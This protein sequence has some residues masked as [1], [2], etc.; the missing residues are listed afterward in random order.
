[1]FKI[2]YLNP[3][4]YAP[5]LAMVALPLL[6]GPGCGS[7]SAP[8]ETENPAN[9]TQSSQEASV[10]VSFFRRADNM[11]GSGTHYRVALEITAGSAAL[12]P[13]PSLFGGLLEDGSSIAAV[14]S[15][16]PFN[17]VV[18]C[19]A[20]DVLPPDATTEC[21]ISLN[22]SDDRDALAVVFSGSSQPLEAPLP[23]EES[24][25]QLGCETQCSSCDGMADNEDISCDDL[26]NA[27]GA[28][29]AAVDWWGGACPGDQ[30]IA[31]CDPSFD[32]CVSRCQASS[33]AACIDDGVFQVDTW[34]KE[35]DCV[36][37]CTMRSNKGCVVQPNA[38]SCDAG[39][40]NG[41]YI[42]LYEWANCHNPGGI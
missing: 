27:C 31:L 24:N 17:G 3:L 37:A 42:A 4:P 18:P 10:S 6:F 33:P 21:V 1:M 16:D 22:V 11:F 30:E 2:K 8:P 28:T 13:D 12:S 15:A 29:V 38:P 35:F 5:S 26:C 40:C 20:D 32:L 9:Q 19:S 25:Q 23:S 39:D 36:D 34:S 41:C 14:A 7:N